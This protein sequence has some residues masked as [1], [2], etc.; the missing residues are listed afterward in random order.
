MSYGQGAN[1]KSIVA[2][3]MYYIDIR[4]HTA[5]RF[6]IEEVTKD[7]LI[8]CM[9]RGHKDFL[10]AYYPELKGQ[11]FTL[12]GYVGMKG[13]VNDPFGTNQEDY[14]QCASLLKK[15]IQKIEEVH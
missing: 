3:D 5:R 14:N 7:T 15:A 4:E 13:E 8:L 12:L 6:D 1:T 2:M 10:L 11:I 9:T